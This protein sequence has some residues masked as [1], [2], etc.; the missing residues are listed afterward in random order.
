MGRGP[1]R[2]RL[3]S[4]RACLGLGAGTVACLLAAGCAGSSSTAERPEPPPSS[5]PAPVTGSTTESVSATPAATGEP[6]VGYPDSIVVLGHSGSTGESSDPDRL[7]VEVR[8]NSW[9]TGTN[10][11]VNSLY[12]RLLAVH[13]QIGGH[14]LALSQGGATVTQLKTQAESAVAQQPTNPLIVIQI[15]DNDIVCP[16]TTADY[17]TF[18][19]GLREALT[20]LDTGLPTSRL[21]VVTQFG[22]PTTYAP[23]LTPAQRRQLGGTGPCALLDPDGKVVPRELRRLEDVIHGYEARLKAACAAFD[24]CAFDSGAFGDV[25]DRAAYGAPDLNHFSVAGHA[26]AAAIAWKALRRAGVVPVDG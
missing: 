15:M 6:Y 26:A 2:R 24:R 4:T 22:S 16:A 3:R 18:E 23:A 9:V 21:F 12:Q 17:D 5:V 25:V 20:V 13:R 19:A 1:V 14:A 11:A 8:E 10:P 7:G